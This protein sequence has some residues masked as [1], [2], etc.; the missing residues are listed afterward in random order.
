MNDEFSPARRDDRFWKNCVFW[1]F[2]DAARSVV[3]KQEDWMIEGSV[4][5]ATLCR[6]GT[7]VVEDESKE[8]GCKCEGVTDCTV[9]LSRLAA[10]SCSASL[11]S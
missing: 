8:G 6:G 4:L 7:F 2:E 5:S 11:T 9:W 3:A 10:F 1:K